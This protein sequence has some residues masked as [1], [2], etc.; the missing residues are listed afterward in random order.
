M[1]ERE[2]F[3]SGSV[4]DSRSGKGRYD[5]L[6]PRAMREVAIRFE[7]GA[8]TYGDRN[9]ELG[10]PLARLMDSAIRHAFQVLEGDT[11]ENHAAAAA[12]NILAFLETRARI[13]AGQLPAELDNLPK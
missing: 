7:Q 8:L 6:P 5:L 1:S 3:S 13:A 2:K 10:Q 9:W 12:W 4:R 11:S